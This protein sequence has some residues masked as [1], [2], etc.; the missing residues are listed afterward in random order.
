MNKSYPCLNI[1]LK[2]IDHNIKELIY[3]CNAEGIEPAIVTKSFCAEKAV[4]ETIIKEG[5]KTIADA[6][7]KNLIKIQDL[8]CEKLLL[9]IPMKSEISK[10]I[11]YA[12]ISLNSE[13]EII[14][15]LSKEAKK[16]NK[17]HK[18]I[19]MIDLGDLREGILPKDVLP[20]VKEIIKLPNL[21]FVGIGTNL[22]CYGGVIPDENNLGKLLQIKNQIEKELK[23]K[24]SIVSGGNSSSLH[25]IV[26]HSIPRGINQLRIGEAAILGRETAFGQK[27]D[28]FYEDCITLAGE[29]VEL[30]EKPS[31]PEGNIGLDAFGNKPSFIDK[32]I[33][34]RAILAL[35][36]QDIKLDGLIPKDSEIE[37]LGASS[38][39]LL[40]NL[41]K[42]KKQYKIGDTVEFNMNYGCLLTAMTSEYVTKYSK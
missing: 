25:M 18:I 16:V 40:L 29:I 6:R 30:K 36:Q 23:I 20:T 22:T 10:V 4:V 17:I 28:N 32:G 38:D 27:L 13:L 26:N 37:I 19:L 34:K 5:I 42:C 31:M 2:K 8:N 14:K 21:E 39:H 3:L 1:N 33:M 24:F 41:T 9:R 15:E 35:G 11:E 7:I 12:D